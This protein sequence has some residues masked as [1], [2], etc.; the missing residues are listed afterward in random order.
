MMAARGALGR[1]TAVSRGCEERGVQKRPSRFPRRSGPLDGGI[2]P[3]VHQP[4]LG[5]I[6]GRSRVES[7]PRYSR[8]GSPERLLA[9]G[10]RGCERRAAGSAHRPSCVAIDG[11]SGRGML[12][13]MLRPSNLLVAAVGVLFL[14]AA[15][16]AQARVFLPSCGNSAYGG[17]VEPR[18][19]DAGCT[20]QWELVRAR[21]SGWGSA[22]AIGRGFTQARDCNPDCAPGAL[23]EHRA[24]LRVSRIRTCEGRSGRHR[25]F[26]TRATLRFTVPDRDG[27]AIRERVHRVRFV[28][29][30]NQQQATRASA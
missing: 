20:G 18:R 10:R 16:S 17:R 5:L 13:R 29:I 6:T 15:A 7:R 28:L 2:E 8:P 30:C 23:D 21:W 11:R 12:S 24:R 25:R 9:L 14:S 26:Y 4:A 27:S 3:S 22:V 19:W 1:R